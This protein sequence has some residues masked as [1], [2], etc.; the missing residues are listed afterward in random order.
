MSAALPMPL[1]VCAACA[2]VTL[3]TLA[4]HAAPAVA[5]GL[6]W[7]LEQP[8]P[9]QGGQAIPLGRVGDIEFEAPNLG[10][11]ITAGNEPTIEPGV[12]EYTGGGWHELA[13]VCGASDGR[14]AWASPNEFWTIS[15]GRPGQANG[16][17]GELPP[18]ED[19]S[20][21]RFANG[22][23]VESFATLAFQATSYETMD[24]AAC[25]D[26]ADCWFGGDV[27]PLSSPPGAFHLH[28]NGRAI[29][30]QPDDEEH[31]V[32]E[33]LSFDGR[34]YESVQ[35]LNGEREPE[36]ELGNPSALHR[37]EPEED[38]ESNGGSPFAPLY[39]HSE[40]TL[41]GPGSALEYFRLGA[42]SQA[43]WAAAGPSEQSEAPVTVLRTSPAGPW[44]QLVGKQA[45][46]SGES[47][48][49]PLPP[50]ADPEDDA[51]TTLAAEPGGGA[52]IALDTAS[53][54]QHPNPATRALLAHISE[55][56][57]VTE[58]QEVPR[59]GSPRGAAA[60][61][62]CPAAH[63]CWMATTQG[64]LFHLAEEGE[65]QLPEYPD[66]AFSS[67]ITSRPSDESTPQVPPVSLPID[68]SGLLGELT[69][70]PATKIEVQHQPEERVSVPLVSGVRSRL[71]GGT[72][73]EL[74]FHLAVE[75][76]VRLLAKRHRRVVGSTPRKTLGG[77]EHKLLL[78]LDA[79]RWPTNLDL[80]THALAPL[81]TV[82]VRAANTDTI[83]TSLA[84]PNRLGP[85][86]PSLLP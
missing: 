80:E 2:L 65:R 25:I 28:W 81:P 13:T 7:R 38:L 3:L 54:A 76:R 27:L 12:W 62:S 45:S 26:P 69:G 53:D 39:N 42:D 6:E 75:A 21:C 5:G 74:S 73:L 64:W 56:G 82:S 35:L 78:R 60:R 47:H 11:L 77:G 9:P 20:L 71:R 51:V 1:R 19:N 68:D 33:M 50:S 67:L 32:R 85:L 16:P 84:F 17:S 4:G 66:P 57:T 49:E 10:L 59:E 30:A 29:T 31:A 36:E 86:S 72:T 43:L 63:D 61:I 46:E 23:V 15:D 83:S 41:P 18:L 40:L 37:I 34:L 22:S 52:W 44:Q 70:P 14:I 79:K 48:G 24:A 58:E 55:T 8:Q